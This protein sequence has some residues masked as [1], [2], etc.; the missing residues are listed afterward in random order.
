[1]AN[2]GS[3]ITSQL[4]A[5]IGAG[6]FAG[7][8]GWGAKL[9]MDAET[10]QA[11]FSVLAGSAEKARTMLAGIKQFA[12]TS[13]LSQ[14]GLRDSAQTMLAFG[15]SLENIMPT[16]RQLGD[17]SM[18]D[19]QRLQSMALAFSQVTAAGRLM[20]QD[21][22]QMVNAGFNPLQEISRKTGESLVELKSRMEAGGISSQEIADAFRTATEAGGKFHG[23]MAQQAGTTAGKLSILKDNV[24][25]LAM[26]FG[27]ALIPALN[28]V[29]E[30]VTPVVEWFK[31]WEASTKLN[32][33]TF[34]ALAGA[35]TAG[36]VVLATVVNAVKTV[37]S[38]MR[39][40]A[41]SQAIVQALS[42]PKGWLTL[43]A[44]AAI[45]AGA[46]A[47][48]SAMFDEVEA[49]AASVPPA[50]AKSVESVKKLAAVASEVKFDGP[51][52]ELSAVS[53]AAS[54][55]EQAASRLN[56]MMERGA[57]LAKE[58]RTPG[59]EFSARAAELQELL[60]I[61]AISG[62]TFRRAMVDAR[63]NAAD[64][65]GELDA[66]RQGPGGA[67]DINTT[68]GF[69][70]IQSALREADAQRREEQMVKAEMRMPT[71]ERTAEQQLE[72][73]RRQTVA[74]IDAGLA[75]RELANAE[76]EF[77]VANF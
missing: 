18:G 51:A 56:D 75:L 68:G 44:G 38:A 63:K 22:L 43:A 74:L 48:V 65:R 32:I 42:G 37:V 34:G 67:M 50:A 16:L 25:T 5:T 72:E 23:M 64:A 36:V 30:A 2:V 70:A 31:S 39:A 66:M 21:L 57:S 14:A 61:G 7:F 76:Q 11:S 20:G 6:S 40:L 29:V 28:S 58:M 46:V 53:F 52:K 60:A 3:G 12:D 45:A 8:F 69:S 59:E 15:V 24:A 73:A 19:E 77:L 54:Q 47:G 26:S 4:A 71:L 62:E 33:V 9:A 27:E 49:K 55:A 10:A 13:P 1:V 35:I 17:L 41:A